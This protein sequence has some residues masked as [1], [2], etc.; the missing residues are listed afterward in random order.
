MTT[1]HCLPSGT[2]AAGAV[3]VSK[4][5]RQNTSEMK[6]AGPYR[7]VVVYMHPF[8][9]PPVVPFVLPV[10]DETIPFLG[11]NKTFDLF[12]SL[13]ADGWV[14]L[15]V[16]YPEDYWTG[17]PGAAVTSDIGADAAHG[18]RFLAM[19][20]HWW[21]HVKNYIDRTYGANWPIALF[22]ISWGGI[23]T[24]NIAK[25]DTSGRLVG[26]NSHVGATLVNPIQGFIGA[27]VS[28]TSGFD[29]DQHALDAVTFPCLLSYGTIDPIVGWGI[30]GTGTCP[31]GYALTQSNTDMLIVNAQA[32]SAPVTRGALSGVGHAVPT[33]AVTL[34]YNWFVAN[35]Y[36][37]ALAVL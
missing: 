21:D 12:T 27:T 10:E 20:L 6:G 35:V 19:T 5:D 28:N 17:G 16:P 37:H 14:I 4:V 3:A 30:A 9:N 15:G 25:A 32:A 22:S 34:I 33:A 11:D 8:T 18:A 26:V 13:V 2:L 1:S 24:L 36:P 31:G 29:V 7:G 23:H